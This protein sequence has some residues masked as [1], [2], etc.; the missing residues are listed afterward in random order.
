MHK[1]VLGSSQVTPVGVWASVLAGM[2]NML[3]GVL[4]ERWASS[5]SRHNS[6]RSIGRL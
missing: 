6:T 4:R 1:R 5:I 3:A 2:L